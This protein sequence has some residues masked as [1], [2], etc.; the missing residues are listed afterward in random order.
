MAH[1]LL[2]FRIL[3]GKYNRVFLKK[4]QNHKNCVNIAKM[5][6]TL[7]FTQNCISLTV[8][9]LSYHQAERKNMNRKKL[10]K[11]EHIVV[12]KN[13][14]LSNKEGGNIFQVIHNIENYIRI[15]NMNKSYSH[16]TTTK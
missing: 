11:K 7:L 13:C 2:V 14:W 10:E 1:L 4:I 16:T 8:D 15:V 9:I 5:V 3:N 12:T 6:H